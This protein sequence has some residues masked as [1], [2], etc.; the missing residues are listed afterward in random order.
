MPDLQQCIRCGEAPS[1]DEHG[2][3]GHCHWVVRAEIDQGFYLLR[4]YLRRWA[5]FR[6]WEVNHPTA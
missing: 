4:E 6:A 1:V 5:D 2:Y 3:C